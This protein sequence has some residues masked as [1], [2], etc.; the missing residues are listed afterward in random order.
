M[1]LLAIQAWLLTGSWLTAG[2]PLLITIADT[3]TTTARRALAGKRITEAHR[4]HVYQ[5]MID[6][7]LSHSHMAVVSAALSLAACLAT[8]APPAIA[9]SAW[10]VVLAAYLQMPQMH[11]SRRS[12]SA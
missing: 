3:A 4:G 6:S 8:L 10:I 5:R 1:S 2:A 11:A 12:S 7:G 9:V